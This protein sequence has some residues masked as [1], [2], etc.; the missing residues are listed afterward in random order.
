MNIVIR[1]DASQNIGTGHFMRCLTL[2][3]EAKIRGNRVCFIM[4]SPGKIIIEKILEH[5]HFIKIINKKKPRTIIPE[6]LKDYSYWLGS[7]QEEDALETSFII[8]SLK[9]DWII[10][11]HYAIDHIW[12]KMMKSLCKRIMVIDDLMNRK[13]LCDLILN[14][15]LG[16]SADAY[17][18]NRDCQFLIGPKFALLRE[19]FINWRSYSLKRRASTEL[20]NVLI[21]MGGVDQF[22]FTKKI[23]KCLE[24]SKNSKRLKFNVIVGAAYPFKENLAKFSNN[25][26]LSVK[27]HI[28][29]NNIA[30][31]MAN[32]D[33]CIGAAGSTSWERCCLGLPTLTFAV[34][35]NQLNIAQALEKNGSTMISKIDTFLEDFDFLV[36]PGG[37][38]YITEFLENSM[39]LCDGFGV[40]RVLGVLESIYENSHC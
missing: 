7:T 24:K 12:H 27:L 15:N 35:D 37:S 40:Q 6:G 20:K 33:L 2:A 39:K 26:D 19:E 10:V 21:T 31:L 16:A 30:E 8:K 34:A 23:L 36:S 1:T 22:D 9:P 18:V 4:R 5:R 14:Q 25:S 38:E 3:D 28:D 11:D 32:S 17:Q 13:L 29:T